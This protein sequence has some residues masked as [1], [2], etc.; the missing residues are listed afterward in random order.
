MARAIYNGQVIAESDDIVTVE[1][2]SYFPIS[3]L[4]KDV[5]SDSDHSTVCGWK[6]TAAYWNITVDGQTATNAAW[7]Y[8]EPMQGAEQVTDRVAFYPA[9]TVEA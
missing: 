4:S 1:G 3:S 2:N 7:Y 9:V 6:G 5:L 8:P